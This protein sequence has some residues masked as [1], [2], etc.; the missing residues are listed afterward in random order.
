MGRILAIDY[1]DA[2]IGLAVSDPLG[3]IA[4]PLKTIPST[5]YEANAQAIGRE[6]EEHLV[7]RVVIGLP[8]AMGGNDTEQTRN[9][10]AFLAVLKRVIWLP[11]EEIDERL[12]TVEATRALQS[13]GVK[14]GHHKGDVDKT[15]AAILLQTYLE[16]RQYVPHNS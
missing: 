16:K 4:S 12:S 3:M 2:R 6:I 14:T 13:K 9:V 11:V 1:G 7:E 10:R 8:L 5:T 15:A